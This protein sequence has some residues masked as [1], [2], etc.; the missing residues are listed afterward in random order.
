MHHGSFNLT[1]PTRSIRPPEELYYLQLQSI[2]VSV[3][4]LFI[5]RLAENR[6]K[7]VWRL[8]MSSV[9]LIMAL[10][11]ARQPPAVSLPIRRRYEEIR[12]VCRAYAAALSSLPGVV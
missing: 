7:S 12:L 11:I 10:L 5:L 8:V 3:A 9:M 6:M 2:E 1:K 4:C